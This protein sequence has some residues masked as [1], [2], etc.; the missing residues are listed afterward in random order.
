MSAKCFTFHLCNTINCCRF[1]RDPLITRWFTFTGTP[2]SLVTNRAF[3][4]ALRF[5]LAS[6]FSLKYHMRPEAQN[7]WLW[8]GKA[9]TSVHRCTTSITTQEGYAASRLSLDGEKWCYEFKV[10]EGGYKAEVE[11][12]T[13]LLCIRHHKLCLC[14]GNNNKS[15]IGAIVFCC[16]SQRCTPW[17]YRACRKSF[18]G[19][20]N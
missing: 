13:A 2:S 15:T 12:K 3:W 20:S 11:R 17:R 10:N 16:F 6:F 18:E 1:S 19:A 14:S 4:L 7:I 9:Y 8:I 5:R